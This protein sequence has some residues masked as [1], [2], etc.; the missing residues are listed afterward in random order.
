MSNVDWSQAPEG[1]IA[2]GEAGVRGVPVWVFDDGY[3]H[4]HDGAEKYKFGGDWTYKRNEIDIIELR[5][6]W[7]SDDRIDFIG[8][9]GNDGLHYNAP[10]SSTIDERA[11][12]K[13]K[14]HRIIKGVEIDLY[15]VLKAYG[16]T[17]PAL[18]HAIK[19]AMLP[20]ARHAKSFE[21]DIDEAITS[22]E[23]AKEL[24]AG[25]TTN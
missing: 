3:M 13:S 4:I 24:A 17:C 5:Q 20:G 9:N 1:G 2:Y 14:Y 19:K 11:E 6:Q 8:V 7:P 12:P 21:Q 22:L 23:R 16:V 25:T 15:D 18:A 10:E